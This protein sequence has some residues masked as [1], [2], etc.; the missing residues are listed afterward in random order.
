MK[1]NTCCFFF[2]NCMSHYAVLLFVCM[3]GW[4][5]TM[6]RL[7]GPKMGNGARRCI[8]KLRRRQLSC[9]LHEAIY[10][11]SKI[12]I[13][14]QSQHGSP[15]A[16]AEIPWKISLMLALKKISQVT[17][18]KKRFRSKPNVWNHNSLKHICRSLLTIHPFI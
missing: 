18:I 17:A 7:I 8:T 1:A 2:P 6:G 12:I 16:L 5:T 4:A 14:T 3:S 15:S 11:K 13:L 10:F 9:C